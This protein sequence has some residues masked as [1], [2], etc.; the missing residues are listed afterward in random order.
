MLAASHEKAKW[1][2]ER[3]TAGSDIGQ[4]RSAR[5]GADEAVDALVQVSK[6]LAG[7][8]DLT[9]VLGVAVGQVADLVGAEGSS[10]LLIDPDTGG[11]SFHVAGG[12]GATVA[13]EIP[14]PPGAGICGHVARTGEALIVNDA[15]HDERLYRRVDQATGITTW[16][17][18]CV[19]LTGSDRLWGVLELINKHGRADFDGRDL[20]VTEAIGA[21]IALAL[22]NA[23]LHKEIVRNERMTAIGHTVSGLAHCVKNILNGIRS[24]SAVVDRSMR[25]DDFDR[26]RQGWQTVRKNNDMLGN[27]VLDMLSLA[28]DTK[29]RPFPTDIDDLVGQVCALMADR[30]RE[31]GIR[32]D[33]TPT[34]NDEEIMTDPTQLYRCV[35][36][37]ISNAIDACCDGGRVRVRVY[38]GAGRE[39]LTVSIADDGEGIPPEN[40]ARLFTGFFTTKGGRGTGLGLPVTRKLITQMGGQIAFHSV[41]GQGTRFVIAL[42]TDGAPDEQ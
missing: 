28:R 30:G 14:L 9:D 8:L 42:P 2:V 11:M 25:D 5:H 37:L 4:Y 38:R 31:R 20:R 22:E 21:P 18:L 41:V 1:D 34:G 27:L 19:P 32:T 17:I 10:I 12:P 33:F 36:N 16:N 26:A 24:G 23:H 3:P 7:K 29:F 13:R 15:Q 35:L 39:R 6:A 40:R